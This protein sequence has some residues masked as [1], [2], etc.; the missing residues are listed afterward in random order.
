MPVSDISVAMELRRR[1][2]RKRNRIIAGVV[3]AVVVFIF[4]AIWIVRSSSLLC[5]DTIE[6]HGT[7]LVT[8]SQ[9]EQAAKVLKG[10]P[11]ARV[12]TDDVAARVRAMD[13]VQQAEVHRKWPHTVVID[14]TELKISYQ[15]KTPGGY[16]WIDPS[17]RIFNRS[18]KPM[19][20]VVWATTA[21]GNHDLLRD[22]ATVADSFP[23]QLRR[24][25]DHIE[26]K[27]RDAIVVVLSGK[28]TVVWGS[29]DQ[30][31]LK[32]KVITAM[33][34]VKATCYDVSSPEHPTSR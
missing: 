17:G 10:Q 2:R 3:A 6:V 12:N 29:A 27:S 25:V 9:V 5:V 14:V 24:Y 28:R 19:P 11:L 15:V 33:L 31:V 20:N 26:A 13:I 1:R 23:T 18:A 21:S 34:H 4:V 8:A 7:H 32:A 16:L 30:S 22:V